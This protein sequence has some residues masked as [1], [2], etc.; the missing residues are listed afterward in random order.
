MRRNTPRSFWGKVG[1]EESLTGCWPWNGSKVYAYG[2]LKWEGKSRRAHRI[3]WMLTFGP[4]PDELCV[5]HKCDNPLCCNP[6]HLFLG[7][8]ADNVNDKVSKL[9]HAFGVNHGRAKVTD[10][11]VS[12]IRLQAKI[13]TQTE[14]ARLFQLSRA[15]IQNIIFRRQWRHVVAA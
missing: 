9:R 13:L 15:Q 6:N 11:Q 12:C 1:K 2:G 5:C 7:T 4:I 3:A 8:E 10:E 14:L